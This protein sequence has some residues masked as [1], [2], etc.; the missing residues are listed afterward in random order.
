MENVINE[1][2]SKLII[3]FQEYQTLILNNQAQINSRLTTKTKFQKLISKKYGIDLSDFKT[4]VCIVKYHGIDG[5]IK[6]QC[7]TNEQ[8]FQIIEELFQTNISI[9]ELA[10]KYQILFKKTIRQWI[11]YHNANGQENKKRLSI[12]KSKA[13][14]SIGIKGDT[15]R[16]F[17]S[18][19]LEEI[20]KKQLAEFIYRI[21]KDKFKLV[22]I[23]EALPI[24]S[25]LYFYY[26]NQFIHPTH[27]ILEDQ[28]IKQ[29]ILKIYNEHKQKYGLNRVC[30]E[31]KKEIKINRKKVHRLMRELGI[32][33]E[34]ISSK[35]KYSTAKGKVGHIAKNKLNQR[36]ETNLPNQKLVADITEMKSKND[37]KVYLQIIADLVNNQVVGYS[38]SQNPDVDF[39]IKGLNSFLVN[40]KHPNYKVFLH[41]DQGFHYQNKRWV[42]ALKNANITQSMSR[43]ATCLDNACVESIFAHIKNDL[44]YQ[45]KYANAKEL[46]SAIED[47]IQ[48]YNHKRIQKRLGY[49]S[50][51]EYLEQKSNEKQL[52][53]V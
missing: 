35:K 34:W 31:L 42:K 30:G 43:L 23:L 41:T 5:L 33:G 50:P 27:K 3:A 4:A 25:K 10:G 36:F 46:I 45:K 11:S 51:V 49:L 48:Y 15:T 37:E 8:K 38:I 17:K 22:D 1:F 29:R 39:A 21:L 16:N 14:T 24:D 9:R 18:L 26:Q 52:I 44:G 47:E 6:N 28:I 2:R 12:R 13:K 40:F 20:N 32:K 19:R 7:Y 53:I